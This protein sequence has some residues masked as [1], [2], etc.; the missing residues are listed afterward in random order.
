MTAPPCGAAA[1]RPEGGSRRARGRLQ[2]AALLLCARV[3][4]AQTSL[5]PHQPDFSVERLTPAPG[6]GVAWQVEDAQIGMAF[7]LVTSLE[8]RPLVIRDVLMQTTLIEPVALRLDLD[9]TGSL[10]FGRFQIGAGLPI[11]AFQDGDRLR[12][13]DLGEPGAES[14]LAAV[15]RGD[16]RLA[17]KTQI[18]APRLGY[19]LGVAADAVLTLPTG[20]TDA[21]AGEAGPVLELRG[22]ASYR[23]PRWAAALNLGPRFRTE[24]V[25]FFN[26]T[27]VQGNELAWGVAGQLA[28][29]V[30]RRAAPV[31]LAE[32][33]GAWGG[34]DGPS[35]AEARLG[36]RA[37]V[38]PRWTLGIAGGA[39]IGGGGAIGAPAWRALVELRFE[40]RPNADADGDGIPDALDQCPTEPE[41]RDGFQDEDG[42][43]DPDNDG[44]GIP[45]AVDQCPNQPE[46]FDG[47]QDEDGCPDPDNDGDG[48]PDAVDRC[49]NQPEDFDG[50]QDEDGCPDK[51]NDGDGIPDEADRCPNEPEDRDGY[52]DADG[53]PDLDDDGDGVPDKDDRCPNEAEDRDGW[54]DED[55]CADLDD[56]RDGVPDAEDKCPEAP[57][58][59]VA[60]TDGRDDGCPHGAPMVVALPDGTLQLDAAARAE[61]FG[62][63]HAA[64]V[65]VAIARAAHWAGW[66][67]A[68]LPDGSPAEALVVTVPIAERRATEVVR[69]LL[70]QGVRARVEASARAH[71]VRITA[72]PEALVAGKGVRR[73][74]G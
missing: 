9:L 23:G 20:D 33:A 5:V 47:F 65:V 29:P 60:P 2:V 17:W 58:F 48:I 24:P 39:G 57:G 51:D 28:L 46:D 55:G 45:D 14:P 67:E 18:L 73:R 69:G 43:P 68:R 34:S 32:L 66:D 16:L 61:L 15:T 12:G 19:G 70:A 44:D 64:R 36:L 37:H 35:P 7:A 56:D 30:W 72:T 6:P 22:V 31:A 59:I 50:F 13:L 21:F 38:D 25:R 3:A 54:Q 8:A 49:P 53:C 41:D 11:V 10:S 4:S 42:C 63:A 52:Q 40:P 26:P 27:V 1:V 62:G 74:G 71:T